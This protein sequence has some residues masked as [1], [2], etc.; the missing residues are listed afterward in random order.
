MNL[1]LI[2]HDPSLRNWGI[3]VIDYDCETTQLTVLHTEVLQHTPSINIRRPNQRDLSSATHHYTR[4]QEL[5]HTY[6]P[7]I[8]IAE[9]PTG[10]QSARASVGYGICISILGSLRYEMPLIEVTPNQVK[11]LVGWGNTSK[12]QIV[13]WVQKTHPYYTFPQHHNEL[14]MSKAEHIADAIVAAHVG[15]LSKQFKELFLCKS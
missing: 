10:S 2:S 4:I 14:N 12:K 6:K 15:L 7:S 3:A 11:K 8:S 1:R 13:K 9:I 5:Y